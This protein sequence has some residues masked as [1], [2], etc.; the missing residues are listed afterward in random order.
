MTDF[1]G[2]TPDRRKWLFLGGGLL[3]FILA[4][5]LVA[6]FGGRF[7]SP[8]PA[9]VDETEFVTEDEPAKTIP[10]GGR[11]AVYV[12]GA[13]MRPGVYEV[14]PGSRVVDA[15]RAGGGFSVHADPDAINLAARVA[16][17]E[18]V[19]IP[20]KNVQAPVEANNNAAEAPPPRYTQANQGAAQRRVDINSAGAAELRSLP[21]IGPG[22]SQAIV[23]YRAANGPFAAPDDLMKVRGIGRKRFDA[24]KDLITT[25]K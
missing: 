20:Y 1:G 8:A 23:D 5:A 16:D 15:L 24:L 7:A 2:L 4:F 12:S 9:A 10:A 17:G 18:H 13:V 6:A 14:A 11:W 22:L 3:C 19:L 21:G 25:G